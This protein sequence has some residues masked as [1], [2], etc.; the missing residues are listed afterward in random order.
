MTKEDY[1]SVA[2][3]EPKRVWVNKSQ[4]N[5]G[6]GHSKGRQNNLKGSSPQIRRISCRKKRYFKMY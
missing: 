2:L 5:G 4:S 3:E 1:M 6:S